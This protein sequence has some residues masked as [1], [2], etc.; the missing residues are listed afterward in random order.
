MAWWF[1]TLVIG[2]V[3]ALMGVAILVVR[4]AL[5]TQAPTEP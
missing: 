3:L 5:G 4:L 2:I 1:W